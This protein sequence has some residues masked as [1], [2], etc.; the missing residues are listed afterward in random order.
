MSGV[1]VTASPNPIAAIRSASKRS[2]GVRAWRTSTPSGGRSAGGVGQN[3]PDR[4]RVGR[5]VDEPES[6]QPLDQVARRRARADLP[7][8]GR[9]APLAQDLVDLGTHLGELV[10][11]EAK[12]LRDV[13]AGLVAPAHP[14]HVPVGDD[15]LVGGPERRIGICVLGELESLGRDHPSCFPQAWR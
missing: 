1:G 4:Q 13:P 9:P 2:S 5:I 7:A 10:G 6:V 14:E 8:A 12:P 11:A 15:A 3:H